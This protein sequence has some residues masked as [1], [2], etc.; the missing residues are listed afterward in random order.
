M[1]FKNIS[2]LD[3]LVLGDGGV[4]WNNS[5]AKKT[6]FFSQT[7]KYEEYLVYLHGK[8]QESKL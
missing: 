1:D 6:S 8:L 5:S 2:Y 3:G 7:C 4:Y